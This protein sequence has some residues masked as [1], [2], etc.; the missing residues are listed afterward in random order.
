MKREFSNEQLL[1]TGQNTE[2]LED[3]EVFL[4]LDNKHPL[5]I[6][7]TLLLSIVIKSLHK[8]PNIMD[9]AHIQETALNM[10]NPDPTHSLPLYDL[11]FK[12]QRPIPKIRVFTR[13]KT[14]IKIPP[15][16]QNLHNLTNQT[17]YSSVVIL[18][19]EQNLPFQENC[20]SSLHDS[21]G[22]PLFPL[23]NRRQKT[24]VKGKNLFHIN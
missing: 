14:E 1:Q 20:A 3:H 12:W 7:T 19:N 13:K 18:I 4:S 17:K 24:K 15:P 23:I 11:I 9:Y 5:N 6:A 22:S 21:V 10:A 8:V 16:W 2:R